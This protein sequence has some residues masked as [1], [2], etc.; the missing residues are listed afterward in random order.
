MKMAILGAGN[1]ARKMAN[2]ITQMEDIE[3]YA[4]ASRDL[5]KAQAFAKKWGISK[6]YGSYEE[7][8]EDEDVELVYVCTPHSFHYQ[9][10]MMCLEHRKHVLCE[11]PFTVNADEARKVFAFAKEKNLLAT[12]GLWTRY[13]PMRLVLDQ[14]LE[15][16]IIGDPKSLTANLCYPIK[17]VPRMTDPALAGGALLDVGVYPINFAMMVFG[18]KIEHISS[19]CTKTETGV[20]AANSITLTFKNG[21]MAILHSSMLCNSDRRG[22]IF[23]TKGF[24]EFL[25]I[26][27]CEGINVYDLDYNLIENYKPFKF[28]TGFEHEVEA[29]QKAIAE[30]KLECKQMPHSETIQVMEIMDGLR[31][32]WGITY[33]ME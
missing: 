22:M 25:N 33:P 21:N 11:K 13:L 23:G 3:A 9:H 12:E 17:G 20:D 2:T 5:E 6:A 14:I 29:S 28:I 1:I 30:G 15:R 26:N 18:N 16:R 27:N 19:T 10:M 24:I 32:E 31:K 8:L 7:M 4:V